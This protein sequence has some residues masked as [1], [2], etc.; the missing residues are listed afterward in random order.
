MEW[1]FIVLIVLGGFVLAYLAFCAIV[2]SKMLKLAT[3]PVAHTLDHAR[4]YQAEHEGM[5][6]ADYDENWKTQS[7]EYA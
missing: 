2:A 1:Y 3:T 4:A 5:E 6:Y 7:F